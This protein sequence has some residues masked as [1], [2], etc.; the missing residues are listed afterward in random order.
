[1]IPENANE[2]KT[3]L[4]QDIAAAACWE[5]KPA[6]EVVDYGSDGTLWTVQLSGDVNVA[7]LPQNI[8]Q[9]SGI[10]EGFATCVETY[11]VEICRNEINSVLCKKIDLWVTA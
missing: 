2:I 10:A 8:R 3:A 11:E 9:R 6:M 7:K 4:F 1:M 5:E